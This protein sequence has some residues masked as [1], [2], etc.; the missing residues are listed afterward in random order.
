M[1]SAG[2]IKAAALSLLCLLALAAQVPTA[3][4][5][6]PVAMVVAVDTSRSLSPD[7]LRAA[8]DLL[9]RTLAELPG[10]TR[11]RLL[12]FDD[13]PPE[14]VRRQPGVSPSEVGDAL[15]DLTLRGEDTV[16]NDALVA[17]TGALATG[18]VILLATDG[19]D[20]S[21]A[22]TLED[23]ARRC[24]DRNIR[25]LSVGAGH[26]QERTLRRLAGVSDGVYL[27]EAGQVGPTAV[28]LAVREALGK[29]DEEHA[30]PTM[31]AATDQVV[32]ISPSKAD[33]AGS[34]RGWFDWLQLGFIAALLPLLWNL[35]SSGYRRCQFRN[36]ILREIEEI[37]PYLQCEIEETGSHPGKPSSKEVRARWKEHHPKKRFLHRKIFKEPT[38]N[39]DFIL[40][41]PPSLVYY[42]SQLWQSTDDAKQWLY[43]INKIDSEVPRWPTERR[44]KINEVKRK[45]YL[46]MKA[47]GW[48]F[49]QGFEE[50]LGW[51]RAVLKDWPM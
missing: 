30:S 35:I 39:R 45:W 2:F 1:L 50:Q 20:E 19:R 38:E 8:K 23:V 27:G 18:G 22:T 14:W 37:G 25:V 29:V 3:A 47:Y 5:E 51:N 12:R 24:E 6:A 33:M 41:L 13:D 21:S 7:H 32:I 10:D 43:M 17:A 11:V 40:S 42:V 36:L 26:V 49:D 48:S 31:P 44:E 15:G 16:L 9:R 46:L 34:K 28:A 4:S